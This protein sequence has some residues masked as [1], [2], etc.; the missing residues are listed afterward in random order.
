M[1]TGIARTKK[2]R[3]RRVTGDPFDNGIGGVMD[4]ENVAD[5]SQEW[6]WKRFVFSQLFNLL[7]VNTQTPNTEY[8]IFNSIIRTF[9]RSNRKKKEA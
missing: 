2:K 1:V 7:A 8:L 3:R 9:S 5:D 6:V 4:T